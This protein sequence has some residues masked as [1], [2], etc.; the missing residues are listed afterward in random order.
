[1]SAA[2]FA[3]PVRLDTIGAVP[4]RIDIAADAGERAALAARFGLPEI[5]S[6]EAELALARVGEAVVAEGRVRGAAT[7]ACIATGE[8]VAALVDEAIALRFVATSGEAAGEVELAA[9]DLDVI[10]HDGQ[11][12]DI[13]EAAAESFALALDPF[14]RC[15]A[16]DAA[17]REAGVLR[18]GEE[19]RGPL[20]GLAAL[21]GKGG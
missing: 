9:G 12:I 19:R 4:R 13:G 17:L 1:M 21:L 7:Q 6:L 8:P 11:A 10:E 15:L 3:R 18:E 14:P 20:S 5:A 16:A 2:E